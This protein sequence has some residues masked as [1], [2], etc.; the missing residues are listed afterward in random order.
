MMGSGE[1]STHLFWRRDP[2]NVA[3]RPAERGMAVKYGL[4]F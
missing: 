3:M 1:V 4:S 2:G